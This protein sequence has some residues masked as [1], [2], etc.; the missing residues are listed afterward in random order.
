MPAQVYL[1][2]PGCISDEQ[3]QVALDHFN[4][5][6][7]VCAQSIPFGLFRQNVFVSSTE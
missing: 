3:F 6:R 7:F 1:Q 4:L 2:R 5:G